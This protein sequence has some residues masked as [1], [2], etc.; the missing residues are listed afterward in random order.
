MT[1][2]P[3]RGGRDRD[4]PGQNC[5]PDRLVEAARTLGA[6]SRLPVLILYAENDTYF[7][8]ALSARVGAAFQTGDASAT[9]R[10]LP[11]VGSEGHALI[12]APSAWSTDVERFL[13]GV[14]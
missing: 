7:P 14:R 3:G 5:S 4:R 11:P 12:E 9:F 6:T 10:L 1:F 2:T 13:E 8:P